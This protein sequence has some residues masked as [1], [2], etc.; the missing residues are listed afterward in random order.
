MS[1]AADRAYEAARE[2]IAR[3]KAEGGTTL[4]F[5]SAEFRALDRLPPEI[6]TLTG[7]DYLD[8]NRTQ[9]ADIAPLAALSKLQRLGL[10]RTQVADLRPLAGLQQLG[11]DHYRGLWFNGAAATAQD[12]ELARLVEIE[13]DRTR[14]RD[15]LAYLRSLPP[16]PAPYTPAARP[17]GRP[18]EPIGGPA[19]P[20]P[21]PNTRVAEAHIASLIRHALV[22][23]A[24]A[25]DLS[26]K[27][28][29]AL[30]GVPATHGNELAPALQTMLD[31]ALVLERMGREEARPDDT[32]PLLRKIAELEAKVATLTAQLNDA[33]EATKAAEAVAA[34]DG[35]WKTYSKNAAASAGKATGPLIVTGISGTAVY[36][37]GWAHPLTDQ[38]FDALKNLWKP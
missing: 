10:T 36:F 27:I 29:E 2:K 31:I 4:S 22:T 19:A 8:L 13:H 9:V 7:V 35:L 21:P 5:D 28:F 34:K 30:R 24:Q 6:G 3:V 14:T 38:L 16:W 33:E 12:A 26:D 32:A 37:L 25:S 23:K 15:T 1:E 20:P 18:P 11:E 17:D